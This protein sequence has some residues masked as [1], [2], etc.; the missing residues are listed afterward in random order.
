MLNWSSKWLFSS[1]VRGFRW[2][3]FKCFSDFDVIFVSDMKSG[4]V[5]PAIR[6]IGTCPDRTW[7]QTTA[8][9]DPTIMEQKAAN[10]S[11]P[12]QL[13]R[14]STAVIF[15]ISYCHPGPHVPPKREDTESS[16]LPSECTTPLPSSRTHKNHLPN[17]CIRRIG[18]LR[19]L[20]HSTDSYRLYD[21]STLYLYLCLHHD[22][23]IILHAAWVCGKSTF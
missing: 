12:S 11:W 22:P 1:S 21:T 2:F 3:Q 17:P 13:P 4:S 18:I 5:M 10:S 7:Q 20:M 6:R 14:V 23:I 19:V 8:G 9:Q 16:S 15:S